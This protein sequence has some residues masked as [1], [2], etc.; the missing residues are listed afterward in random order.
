MAEEKTELNP[1]EKTIKEYLD[2]FAATDEWFKECYADPKKNIKSCCDYI[3]TEVQKTGR[4]G[5]ADEE[6]YQLARHYYLEDIKP[7][8]IKASSGNVVVNHQIEL[9]DEEKK[10]AHDRAVAE[11]EAQV[12]AELEKEA[13]KKIEAEEKA[14]AKAEAKKVKD[15]EKEKEKIQKMGYLGTLFDNF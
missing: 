1:F 2:N 14:K 13:R 5:F 7:G 15:A 3:C 11:Y 4:K 9:S 6:I 12:K 10:A 8:E